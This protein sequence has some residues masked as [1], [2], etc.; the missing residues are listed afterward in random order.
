MYLAKAV[1]RFIC[2]D[3]LYMLAKGGLDLYWGF[4]GYRVFT[5]EFFTTLAILPFFLCADFMIHLF[6]KRD[7][8]IYL[9][10]AVAMLA[11]IPFIA[12][13]LRHN[14]NAGLFWDRVAQMMTHWNDVE[15]LYLPL[16]VGAGLGYAIYGLVLKK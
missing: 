16:V 4:P 13:L 2:F 10:D 14:P 7:R 1:I 9:C 8:R 3:A 6:E 5:F 12:S 11:L 15:I